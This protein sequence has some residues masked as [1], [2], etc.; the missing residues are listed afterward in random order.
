ME[1]SEEYKQMEV[2]ANELFAMLEKLC[3]EYQNIYDNDKTNE[4]KLKKIETEIVNTKKQHTDLLTKM[5]PEKSRMIIE[6]WK[7]Y[8]GAV[9]KLETDNGEI[10]Q[11]LKNYRSNFKGE[12]SEEDEKLLSVLSSVDKLSGM[13]KYTLNLIKE[14]FEDT[15]DKYF[16]E[17][18]TK[19][20]AFL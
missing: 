3:D 2:L 18:M 11:F 5:Q 13:S 14:D 16:E 15:E 1:F 20:E 9:T 6:Y 17:L 19:I 8:R 7:V 12:K 4:E 10:E